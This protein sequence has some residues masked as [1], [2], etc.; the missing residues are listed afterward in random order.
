MKDQRRS[1]RTIPAQQPKGTLT[2]S[3]EG[4]CFEIKEV[5]D[6]SPF[7]IGVRIDGDLSKGA[8]IQLRYQCEDDELEVYGVIAWG[9]LVNEEA[10]GE[11]SEK[12]Y[13][14]GI[15]LRPEDVEANLKFYRLISSLNQ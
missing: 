7:G 11:N 6:V 8:E 5:R 12:L 14:I 13:R 1:E 4:K 3:I 15:C 2:L 10:S 9:S